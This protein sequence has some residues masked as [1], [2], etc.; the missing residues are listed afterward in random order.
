MYFCVACIVVCI[1]YIIHVGYYVL[2]VVCSMCV[3]LCIASAVHCYGP[4]GL[5]LV[6]LMC[7]QE[8]SL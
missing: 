5:G 4:V 3:L 2:F 8:Q 7:P 1:M 6:V